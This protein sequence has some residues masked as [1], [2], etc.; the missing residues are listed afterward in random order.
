MLMEEKSYGEQ[1]PIDGYGPGGFRVTGVW[2]KGGIVIAP[3]G[4]YDIDN[5][6]EAALARL[7]E[8]DPGLDTVLVGQGADIAPLGAS[9][10]APL[11]SAGIGVEYMATPPACRT[12]N[13]LLGEERRVAAL[14]LP[15]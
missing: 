1:P 11:E 6:L 2:R 14:L 8:T 3:S 10:R 15:L 4:L 7:L 12:Y 13:V 9:F 5:G